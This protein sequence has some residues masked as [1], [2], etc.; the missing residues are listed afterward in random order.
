MFEKQ[1]PMQDF[2]A[3][4]NLEGSNINVGTFVRRDQYQ[5]VKISELVLLAGIK[6]PINSDF[7][8]RLHVNYSFDY[9]LNSSKVK[10]DASQEISLIFQLP[11]IH[12]R[13]SPCQM[14]F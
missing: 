7:F 12:R 6:F 9:S 8:S 11:S 2:V 1:G 13:R 3:G 14:Y 5:S 10:G 4:I